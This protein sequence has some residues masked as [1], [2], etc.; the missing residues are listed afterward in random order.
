MHDAQQA[1]GEAG[2]GEQGTSSDFERAFRI[3]WE[4]LADAMIPVSFPVDRIAYGDNVGVFPYA[5][6]V[7]IFGWVA[8]WRHRPDGVRHGD[9]LRGS[10]DAT[11]G[12]A[13]AD[14]LGEFRPGPV[15]MRDEEPACALPLKFP[16]LRACPLCI[17][18]SALLFPGFRFEEEVRVRL[19]EYI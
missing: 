6:R 11:I 17:L 10:P 5:P 18:V 2:D 19:S 4:S 16:R 9:M 12:C 8:D 7:F 1:S 13:G 3:A 14:K 15:D